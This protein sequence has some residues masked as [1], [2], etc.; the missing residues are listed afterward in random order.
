MYMRSESWPSCQSP[1]SADD[2]CRHSIISCP[3]YYAATKRS[4]AVTLSLIIQDTIGGS[5]SSAVTRYRIHS[6]SWYGSCAGRWRIA[7]ARE[8]AITAVPK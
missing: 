1:N 4:P 5:S 6:S 8:A 7:H 2:L 3:G